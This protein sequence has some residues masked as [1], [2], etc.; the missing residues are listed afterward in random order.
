MLRA[1][2][3]DFNGVLVDDEPVHLGLFQRVLREEGISLTAED[4]YARYLGMDDRGCFK[5]AYQEHGRKLDEPSL[6]ELIRR[7]ARYYREAIEAGILVFPGVKQ[8]IPT[9]SSRFPL[10]V[11]SGALRSE[12][13]AILEGLGLRKYFRALVS[14]EDVS[15]GKPNP[16]I[17]I[18]ALGSLNQQKIVATPIQRSECLVVEDSKE[19]ILG[20][21]CAGM[22][23]LA[24]ANSHPVEELREADAVVSSLEEITVSFLESLFK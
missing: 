22:K 7:K 3:F 13:D 4:Y 9:L 1:I 8:L 24:V 15:E 10:A 5:A 12:I 19:G 16:E 6:A 18:K 14:A 20:A 21:R 11:A 2:I 17:F 23:C